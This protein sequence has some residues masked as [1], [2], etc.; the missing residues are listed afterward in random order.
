MREPPAGRRG[1][2]EEWRRTAPWPARQARVDP[3]VPNEAR[4]W[5]SLTGGRDNFEAD[6]SAARQLIAVSPVMAHLGPASR[7][8]LRRVVTYLVAEAGIRQFLDIGTG[9]PA[10]GSVH[11][12]AQAAD[13]SCRI[14]YLDNDPL[15]IAHARADLRSTADGATSY[16]QADVSDTQAILDGTRQALDLDKPVGVLMIMVLH[17]VEDAAAALAR[18]VAALS[19]GSYLAVVHPV[20]DERLVTAARRWS[21]LG[22]MPVFLRDRAEV[23]RWFAGLDLIEPGLIEVDQWRPA[24]GDRDYPDG[25][26][27]LAAVARKP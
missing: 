5:N 1:M 8:F 7:A 11:S 10:E 19:A 16:I 12:V 4:M 22:G 21:Q 15:V 17:F 9:M 6:R 23:S 25:L 24:P 26:P 27:L 18:L 2:P 13:P 3:S 20:R 14:V